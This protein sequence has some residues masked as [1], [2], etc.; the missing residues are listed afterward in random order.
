MPSLDP[1]Y[2]CG[3]AEH[4]HKGAGGLLVA[5]RDGAPLLEP[6]PKA[7]D[8]VAVLVDPRRAGHG[9]LV[10]LGRDR[11]AAAE[12][13]DE[14]AEGMAG[15]AA[16]GHDPKGNDGKGG[17]QQWRQ[18]QFVRLPG[19]QRKTDGTSLCIGDHAG[20]AAITAPR[21]AE[22]LALVALC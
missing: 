11:R 19:R 4:A 16:I 20:L 22:R 18:R 21:P 13:P 12:A 15:I 8:A 10:A 1:V 9:G 6:R 2:G 14:F 7:L 3:H 17:Q 5:G